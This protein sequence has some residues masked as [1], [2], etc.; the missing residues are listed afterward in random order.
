[1]LYLFKLDVHFL[2]TM[3][4]KALFRP[5]TRTLFHTQGDTLKFLLLVTVC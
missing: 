2:L 1:M 5:Y 4:E 3:L